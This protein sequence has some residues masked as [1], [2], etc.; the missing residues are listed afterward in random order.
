[1]DTIKLSA[2]GVVPFM[3]LISG[4][5]AEE[6]EAAKA[7]NPGSRAIG[8]G[9]HVYGLYDEEEMIPIGALAAQEAGYS[10]V[11]R[12]L[13]IEP[14]FRRNGGA[15]L[16]LT[17]LYADALNTDDVVEVELTAAKDSRIQMEVAEY[18][19][20]SGF[21]TEDADEKYYRTT[22]NEIIKAGV[23]NK[24]PET[25]AIPLN[26]VEDRL[27]KR[28]GNEAA[29]KENTFVVLPILKDDYDIDVSMAVVNGNEIVDLLLVI[30][31]E[32]GLILQY[33]YA[34][35]AG[36]GI[37]AAFAAAVR[38]ACD[39]YGEDT[40]VRIPTVNE[41][42]AKL[43]EKIAPTATVSKFVRCYFSLLHLCESLYG[44]KD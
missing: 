5:V 6:I 42:A 10:F 39:K 38:T 36:R 13:Y 7:A 32:R 11:I 23:L 17:K 37:I 29:E 31:D 15:G 43:V 16:L 41:A 9:F 22:L 35:E 4:D 34:K 26:Q 3:H 12:S 21:D 19:S 20:R 8:D 30:H 2:Q 25:G 1:M 18:L 14:N 33:A 27:L 44:R 40:S 28:F 24:A